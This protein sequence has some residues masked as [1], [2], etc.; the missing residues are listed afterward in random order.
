MINIYEF[1]KS[2]EN[3]E[4]IVLPDENATEIHIYRPSQAIIE[5]LKS[6]N[7]RKPFNEKTFRAEF[8]VLASMILSNN[9][10]K[11]GFSPEWVKRNFSI[12]TLTWFYECVFA[13]WNG[14]P[15]QQLRK[16]VRNN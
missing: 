5:Q 16:R 3:T 15:V 14:E 11:I 10:E 1:A 12:D 13:W 2:T 7:C 9:V 4:L 6:I 8:N